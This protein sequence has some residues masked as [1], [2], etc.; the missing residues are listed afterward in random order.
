VVLWI[1]TSCSL[2]VTSCWLTLRIFHRNVCSAVNIRAGIAQ[3]VERQATGY[4]AGFRFPA[5]AIDFSLLHV[6]RPNL[7]PSQLPIQ[8]VSGLFPPR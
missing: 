6:F 7:E 1:M 5:E 8:W 4:T 2:V 3:S